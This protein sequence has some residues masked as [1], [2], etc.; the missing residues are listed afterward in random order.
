LRTSKVLAPRAVVEGVTVTVDTLGGG[1]WLG[2]R[3]PHYAH[4]RTCGAPFVLGRAM[5][6]GDF[7]SCSLSL[8]VGFCH[9]RGQAL[10]RRQG[11][12]LRRASSWC[13]QG[14]CTKR[15]VCAKSKPSGIPPALE[16]SASCLLRHASCTASLFRHFC[17]RE[18]QSLLRRIWSYSSDGHTSSAI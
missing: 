12:Q 11:G 4:A 10:R 13:N 2:D 3:T 9:D 18:A 17:Q 14:F 6:S 1:R 8:S 15:W 5:D 16:A 7:E